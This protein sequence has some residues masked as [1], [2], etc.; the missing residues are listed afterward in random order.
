MICRKAWLKR[1][2]DLLIPAGIGLHDMTRF[3]RA[4]SG[5]VKFS[6]GT[7]IAGSTRESLE[8]SESQVTRLVHIRRCP[9]LRSAKNRTPLAF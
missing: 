6:T 5:R 9:L 1:F 4:S 2:A 7:D 8:V 3:P